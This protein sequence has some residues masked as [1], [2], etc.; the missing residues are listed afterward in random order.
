MDLSAQ[1]ITQYGYVG[2]FLGLVLGIVGLPIPDETLL[3]LSGYLAYKGTFALFPTC[4]VAFLG[5]AC[6]ITVSYALGRVL[7]LRLDGRLGRFLHLT[8][9]SLDRVHRWFARGGKWLLLVGYFIPGVRH[10]TAIVAG[11][12]RLDVP[13]FALF[14]YT[15]ALLW[16]LTF[17]FIGYCFGGEWNQILQGIAHHRLLCIAVISVV[18][19]AVLAIRFGRHRPRRGDIPP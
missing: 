14:A 9:K 5:S 13:V 3:T 11:T 6:G 2:V 7:G 15:G 16:S 8:P 19:I 10:L 17:I 4:S 18:I 1:W 12:S